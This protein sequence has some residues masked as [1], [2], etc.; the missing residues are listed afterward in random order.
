MAAF[1]VADD[2]SNRIL[3][4]DVIL[5]EFHENVAEISDHAVEV[6]SNIADHVRPLPDRLSLTGYTSNQPIVRNPFT[7]RGEI[8]SV[9]LN[10][11]LWTPP[12]EPTPGSL[13]RNAIAAVEGGIFGA[14]EAVAT[15][16]TFSETF[17]ATAETHEL[18]VE[19]LD[20][21]VPLQIIT[22]LRSYD[23]VVLERVGAPR[24]AGDSGVAFALDIK[25]LRI[26]ESGTVTA[27]P[28]PADDVPGGF[29]LENKGGQ[30]A[31][32]PGEGEDPKS[33]GS[34]VF[35]AAKAKGLL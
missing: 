13:V 11:P 16:L 30:G 10:P 32:L 35:E 23:G 14:P 12:L 9:S 20:N 27:P 22:G 34:I 8:E 24:E 7:Q 4:F 5:A 15:V 6:G 2:D 25:K 31:K 19:F 29:P 26:V 1:I 17:N 18:L 28:V 21:A 3:V 33:S